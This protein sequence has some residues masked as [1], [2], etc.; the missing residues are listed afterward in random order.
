MR[1]VAPKQSNTS[2]TAMMDTNVPDGL[3]P[4]I[5][6]GATYLGAL[7]EEHI[8]HE[9]EAPRVEDTQVNWQETQVHWQG[10]RH[11]MGPSG[12][13]VPDRSS[14]ARWWSMGGKYKEGEEGVATAYEGSLQSPP[15]GLQL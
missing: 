7:W 4:S 2:V 12:Y 3:S 11:V 1:R 13:Y 15:A 5:A 8:R 9:L 14:R 10:S 6:R